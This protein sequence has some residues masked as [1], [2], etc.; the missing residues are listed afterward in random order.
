MELAPVGEVEDVKSI[1]REP[2]TVPIV[3]YDKHLKKVVTKIKFV[4]DVAPGVARDMVRATDSRGIISAQA[5][6]DYVDACVHDDDREKWNALIRGA[7]ITDATVNELY[8][9]LGTHYVN[10][11]FTKQ[12][13]SPDG[14][15]PTKRTT[16]RAAKSPGSKK[17]IS[18]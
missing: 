4:N 13:G 5:A 17:K 1:D 15:S 10:R 2:V 12:S 18:A 7:D 11:P 3:T 14:P 16:P 9:A 8:T 6:L